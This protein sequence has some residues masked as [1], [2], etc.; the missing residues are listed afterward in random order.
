MAPWSLRNLRCYGPERLHAMG[1]I[2][3][4]T[5]LLL[6]AVRTKGRRALPPPFP[7]GAYTAGM[8]G[9]PRALAAR[10]PCTWRGP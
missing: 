3:Y 9:K 1:T 2:M 8:Y 5:R 6:R 4:G 10:T 7:P